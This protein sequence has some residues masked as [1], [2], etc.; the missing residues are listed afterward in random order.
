MNEVKKY[1]CI[2][3]GLNRN[4]AFV[5]LKFLVKKE[6][7]NTIKIH[8]QLLKCSFAKTDGPFWTYLRVSWCVLIM[9]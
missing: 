1:P 7:V 4:N 3:M 5:F 6:L 8:S 9:F 2:P